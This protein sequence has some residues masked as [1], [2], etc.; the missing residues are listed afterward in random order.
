MPITLLTSAPTPSPNA[1]ALS[2]AAA[3][4]PMHVQNAIN[5]AAPARAGQMFSAGAPERLRRSSGTGGVSSL[6]LVAVGRNGRVRHPRSLLPREVAPVRSEQAGAKPSSVWVEKSPVAVNAST[7]AARVNL[8]APLFAGDE[9]DGHGDWILPWLRTAT[10]GIELPHQ[11]LSSIAADNAS[12]ATLA[13]LQLMLGQVEQLEQKLANV[14]AS[15][16]D[17]GLKAKYATALNDLLASK[18]GAAYNRTIGLDGHKVVTYTREPGILGSANFMTFVLAEPSK[19]TRNEAT[20]W[21]TFKKNHDGSRPKVQWTGIEAA[22][23]FETHIAVPAGNTSIPIESMLDAVRE[24]DLGGK[25]G[26]YL[27]E[28]L[29]ERR[30]DIAKHDE[31]TFAFNLAVA[32]SKGNLTAEEGGAIQAW[33][34]ST[35]QP[36]RIHGAHYGVHTLELDDMPAVGAAVI[37]PLRLSESAHVEKVFLYLPGRMEELG[38]NEFA[39]VPGVLKSFASAAALATELVAMAGSGHA[40]HSTLKAMAPPHHEARFHQRLKTLHERGDFAHAIQRT[41]L[42]G[43]VWLARADKF[44]EQVKAATALAFTSN[45]MMDHKTWIQTTSDRLDLAWSFL[46]MIPVIGTSFDLAM[47]F[48]DAMRG[49][50]ETRFGDEAAGA[51]YYRSMIMSMVGAATSVG[52]DVPVGALARKLPVVRLGKNKLMTARRLVDLP[53]HGT[54]AVIAQKPMDVAT[55]LREFDGGSYIAVPRK[56]GGDAYVRVAKDSDLGVYRV[57]DTDGKLKEPLRFDP[58]TQ[59]WSLDLNPWI[60]KASDVDI[61]EWML[62][63]RD[64]FRFKSS[65]V[66]T[67][68]DQ[69]ARV[70]VKQSELSTLARGGDGAVLLGRTV[71]NVVADFLPKYLHAR[72]MESAGN[73]LESPILRNVVQGQLARDLQTPVV[74]LKPDLRDGK[75]PSRRLLRAVDG[76]GAVLD[77]AGYEKLRQAAATRLE[78]QELSPG[79]FLPEGMAAYSIPD[80]D[81]NLISA[82]LYAKHAP[83]SKFQASGVVG[84]RGRSTLKETVA[85]E[86]PACAKRIAKA[87]AATRQQAL[88]DSA[89]QQLLPG[90][91]LRQPGI[92]ATREVLALGRA[93]L[94]AKAPMPRDLEAR[95]VKEVLKSSGA[96]LAAV[97][98]HIP[99]SQ[100]ALASRSSLGTTGLTRFGPKKPKQTLQIRALCDAQGNALSYQHLDVAASDF[101]PTQ[102]WSGSPLLDALMAANDGTL[103]TRLK[104]DRYALDRL[105]TLIQT[106]V[107]AAANFAVSPRFEP[108]VIRDKGLIKRIATCFK[109]DRQ[110]SRCLLDGRAYIE[111]ISA[112]GKRHHFEIELSGTDGV[113]QVLKPAPAAGRGTGLFVARAQGGY[114]EPLGLDGGMPRLAKPDDVG[115]LLRQADGSVLAW[116]GTLDGEDIS[117]VYDLESC[118]WIKREDLAAL[119]S[120]RSEEMLAAKEGS[121]GR[122]VPKG[123]QIGDLDLDR[124]PNIETFLLK[125]AG[126]EEF[127]SAGQLTDRLQSLPAG[128]AARLALREDAARALG[129]DLS[130]VDPRK[131]SLPGRPTAVPPKVYQ[132]WVGSNPFPAQYVENVRSVATHMRA[133]LPGQ[134]LLHEVYLLGPAEVV[135]QNKALLETIPGVTT[136]SLRESP[137]MQSFRALADGR[138]L[139]MLN[140]ALRTEAWSSAADIVRFGLLAKHA[141]GSVWP[142]GG[143]YFD[144]DD[145]LTR[146]PG[147]M[148]LSAPPGGAIFG[149]AVSQFE[150]NMQLVINTDAMGFQPDSPVPGRVLQRSLEHFDAQQDF[151]YRTKPLPGTDEHIAYARQRS[152]YLAGPLVMHGVLDES[153]D[154][155]PH[156]APW[157]EVL[158]APLNEGWLPTLAATSHARDQQGFD[159]VKMGSGHSWA[160]HR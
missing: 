11:A 33:L 58:T 67:L 8:S 127:V 23:R 151:F 144:V 71:A 13:R 117:L 152:S 156:S 10:D 143:F 103:A 153:A 56:Q 81:A 47:V 129:A 139:E 90:T 40:R 69:L 102:P 46:S 146:T 80:A 157:R 60:E 74:I 121:P 128:P 154:M 104:L 137:F 149:P 148:E 59:V 7:G 3:N 62:D 26:S 97:I 27:S 141:D 30:M 159:F 54:Q 2:L 118:S 20:L 53:A 114:W 109:G 6:P 1:P 77:M 119:Y 39:M 57:R 50:Y 106:N 29:R 49:D 115:E 101:L 132:I 145:A 82:T 16:S 63:Q 84:Q 73:G 12:D 19:P 41:A 96:G 76:T 93:T 15:L 89:L 21:D 113:H 34:S 130:M 112:N 87:L 88:V 133:A 78:V 136:R 100:A 91:D 95:I 135:A 35:S 108:Y 125:D 18:F 111:S 38:N 9:S 25:V 66:R 134:N 158:R 105:A 37:Q 24:F 99:A 94:D 65:E 92:R 116:K 51:E 5:V 120:W 61:L 32:T 131:L 75:T 124:G 110:A 68:R 142:G 72:L 43:D 122:G 4:G 17:E 36:L 14:T 155:D 147:A 140:W 70:G 83:A 64:H 45:A 150:L 107:M 22:L 44:I 79:V 160:R 31:A 98:E 52:Q 42:Q 48:N 28:L 86:A 138:Y 55:G 126:G 123:T 85:Q